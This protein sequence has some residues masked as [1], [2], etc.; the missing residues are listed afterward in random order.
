MQIK[1]LITQEIDCD[2]C[3]DVYDDMYPAFCGPICLTEEGKE[4]FAE[5]L[6]Y[7]VYPQLDERLVVVSIRNYVD[8]ERMHRKAKYF[9]RAIAGYIND[10]LW[11]KWF[12]FDEV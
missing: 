9:F 5:V 1:D 4:R 6:E 7:L 11:H 3:D 10:D 8:Y 12:Y 2:V